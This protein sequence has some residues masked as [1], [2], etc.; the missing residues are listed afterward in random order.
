MY[1]AV[2]LGTPDASSCTVTVNVPVPLGGTLKLNTML[3]RS[4][5]AVLLPVPKDW[6]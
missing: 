4:Y 5:P 6:A 2:P 1:S 3:S